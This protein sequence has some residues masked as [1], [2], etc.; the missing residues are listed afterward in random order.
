MGLPNKLWSGTAFR[1]ASKGGSGAVGDTTRAYSPPPTPVFLRFPVSRFS[2]RRPHSSLPPPPP[3]VAGVHHSH[4]AG[5][6]GVP[7][8]RTTPKRPGKTQDF[9][10]DDGCCEA[11]NR[12]HGFFLWGSRFCCLNTITCYWGV[13]SWAVGWIVVVGLVVG[14]WDAWKPDFIVWLRRR[15]RATLEKS[16]PGLDVTCS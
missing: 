9:Q 4:A 14:S 6:R 7:D 8:A 16:S 13:Y 2:P 11:N 1:E 10:L 5:W 15:E 3:L 12:K